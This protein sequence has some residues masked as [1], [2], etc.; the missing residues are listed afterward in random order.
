MTLRK[1]LAVACA[2]AMAGGT[3]PAPLAA[4]T[5]RLDDLK[6][7]GTAE[8]DQLQVFTQQMVDQIFSYGEL[9]FQE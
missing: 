5:P 9:G 8:V 1:L 3:A 7:E 2:L 6:R 4:Q